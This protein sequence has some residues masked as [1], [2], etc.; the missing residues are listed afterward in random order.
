MS[1][2]VKNYCKICNIE[3]LNKCSVYKSIYYSSKEHQKL[4]WS[5]HKHNC[6]HMT[7]IYNSKRQFRKD[8]RVKL[9]EC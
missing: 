1:I 7:E 5:E 6:S 3:S 8:T 9:L 4:D 2:K